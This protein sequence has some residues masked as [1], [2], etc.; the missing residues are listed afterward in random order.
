MKDTMQKIGDEMF[1]M[2]YT[3]DDLTAGPCKD[4]TPYQTVG[5]Y[6]T[7]CVSGPAPKQQCLEGMTCPRCN[8][9]GMCWNTA[10]T[11][12]CE[13]CRHTMSRFVNKIA[14]VRP[15]LGE[16]SPET[17]DKAATEKHFLDTRQLDECIQQAENLRDMLNCDDMALKIVGILSFGLRKSGELLADAIYRHKMA[18]T[19][20]KRVQAIA[21]LEN[22]GS[23]MSA[24]KADG[25]DIKSTDSTRGHYINIDVDVLKAA[26]KEAFC[27]ALVSQIDTYKMQFTMAMSAVKA[28]ISK[29]RSDALISGAATPTAID[30]DEAL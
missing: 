1:G 27:E 24:K 13:N 10:A 11:V 4:P 23:Y 9:G 8:N 20:M 21:A 6:N 26:E 5:H 3:L 25:I 28:M 16:L 12:M 29:Q 19:E 15:M 7:H 14:E 30:P 18:K 17:T 22:F 2:S